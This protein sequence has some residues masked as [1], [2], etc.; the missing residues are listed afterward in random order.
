[1]ARTLCRGRAT[2]E[3][4]EAP[5][6]TCPTCGLTMNHHADKLIQ[7]A[8]GDPALGGVVQAMHACPGCGAG[9]ARPATS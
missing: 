5:A 7:T 1:M 4:A 8:G 2:V 3:A 9:A 6:M